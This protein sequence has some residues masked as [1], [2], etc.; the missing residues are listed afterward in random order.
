MRWNRT[1]LRAA[2]ATRLTTAVET[3]WLAVGESPVLG[4]GSGSGED[5]IWRLWLR[6]P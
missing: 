6:R 1:G 3:A 4:A 5:T 2:A